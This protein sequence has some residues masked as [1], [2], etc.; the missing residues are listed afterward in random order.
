MTS[1]RAGPSSIE[2]ERNPSLSHGLYRPENRDDRYRLKV[3]S[4]VILWQVDLR[5][6]NRRG[7]SCA[8]VF[9]L[10]LATRCRGEAIHQRALEADFF[11]PFT[12]PPEN[13]KNAMQ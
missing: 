1:K 13:S 6:D 2:A 4:A 9:K 8:S 11:N 7:R 5:W 10:G 12:P 3:S